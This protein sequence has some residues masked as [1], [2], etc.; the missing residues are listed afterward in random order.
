[1]EK[2]LRRLELDIYYM[3][4]WSWKFDLQIISKTVLSLLFGKKI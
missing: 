4:N 2:M 1:M 3:E